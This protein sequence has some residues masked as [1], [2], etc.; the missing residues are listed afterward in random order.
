MLQQPI[1]FLIFNRPDSTQKVF[2]QI[3]KAKPKYF[4]IASDG[5]RSNKPDDIVLCDTTRNIVLNN[6]DWDCKITTRFQ[7]AN[8]GCGK[9]VSGAISWFFQNVEQ[10][11]ILEDD[12]VPSTSFFE[13]CDELLYK[14]A[15]NKK[16][17][18]I[19]GSNFQRKSYQE[20]YYFS[21]YGHIWGWAT[22]RRAWQHYDFTLKSISDQSFRN[23]LS[24]YFSDQREKNYWYEVFKKMKTNPV[25]TWDY[26]WNFSIWSN[27]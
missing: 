15:D 6:I 10:G 5:P 20:S 21:A 7:S 19:G 17:Y 3:R 26:Q 12:C 1:L 4:Y 9:H 2:D 8:Q 24:H 23:N 16:I 22:W 18:M 25:D 14:Y 13:F 27:L 11:I